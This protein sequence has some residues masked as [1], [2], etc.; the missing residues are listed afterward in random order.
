MPAPGY[1]N[2]PPDRA[3]TVKMETRRAEDMTGRPVIKSNPI[4]RATMSFLLKKIL[5]YLINWKT[6]LLG[7]SMVCGGI[8]SLAE[9]LHKATEGH[10]LS[11]EAFQ[12]GGAAIIGGFGLIFARDA[13]KS[14]QDSTIR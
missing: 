14:S 1:H 3:P 6:T 2:P 12:L 4:H 7:I 13:D 11:L 10:P 5:P 8:G 9:H